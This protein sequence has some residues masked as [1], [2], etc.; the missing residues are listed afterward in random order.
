MAKEAPGDCFIIHGMVQA[1]ERH[2]VAP[3]A[4][5]HCVERAMQLVLA[6]APVNAYKFENWES[7]KILSPHA[8]F[9]WEQ[10]RR[11]ESIGTNSAFLLGYGSYLSSVCLYPEAE[12]L[13]ALAVEVNRRDLGEEKIDTLI[14]VGSLATLYFLQGR[15]AAAEPLLQWG[16]TTSERLLGL[17]N[18]HT[19]RAVNNLASLYVGQGRL[20]EAEALFHRAL[21][22][23]EAQLGSENQIVLT[24]LNNLADLNMRQGRY[25]DAFAFCQ[26]ALTTQERV[27]GVEHPHTL[28][29]ANNLATMYNIRGRATVQARS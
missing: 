23:S 8:R 16:L 21:L 17:E 27:L 26:R 22:G 18:E 7:W 14:S 4:R 13:L 12:P 6:W 19:L 9:L 25:V 10:Q 15:Y 3:D 11:N 20:T 2:Q 5:T 24:L 1:V 28:Y 29:T